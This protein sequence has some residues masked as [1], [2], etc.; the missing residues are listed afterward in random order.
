MCNEEARCA[1]IDMPARDVCYAVRFAHA[2][3]IRR[4][5]ASAEKNAARRRRQATFSNQPETVSA[6]SEAFQLANVGSRV[7]I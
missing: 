7:A 1:L 3:R 5:T 2:S 6:N 4:K